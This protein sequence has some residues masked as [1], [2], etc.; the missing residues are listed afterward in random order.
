MNKYLY[1]IISK[2]EDI[3]NKLDIIPDY[4][5]EGIISNFYIGIDNY[6]DIMNDA[7][8]NNDVEK[9]KLLQKDYRHHYY[10]NY[11][12]DI[13]IAI[14]YSNLETFKLV[15]YIFYKDCPFDGLI[16][17]SKEELKHLI[18]KTS[19]IETKEWVKSNIDDI[20]TVIDSKFR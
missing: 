4:F 14:L 15:F 5:G 6:R 9:I 3:F 12:E 8:K 19:N 10:R 20:Y 17:V 16:Y 13:E 2:M 18:E 11:A 1:E 7:I